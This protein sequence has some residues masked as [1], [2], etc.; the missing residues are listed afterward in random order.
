MN[1]SDAY[2]AAYNTKPGAS[3]AAISVD[4]C[5]LMANPNVALRVAALR[6]PVVEAVQY[7]LK[8]AMAEAAEALAVSKE[9]QNGGAMVAA[10]ALRAKLSG[11]IIEKRQNVPN[12][13]EEV[14]IQEL[15]AMDAALTAIK[16]A[17]STNKSSA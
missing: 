9:K 1:Q 5:K 6:K 8:E 13:F 7:G 11:L 15:E 2:R 3:P 10:V 16:N 12:P 4:A 14:P 17:R